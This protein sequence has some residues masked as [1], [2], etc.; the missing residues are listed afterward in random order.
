LTY[1]ETDFTDSDC[2][3]AEAQ[4]QNRID[5]ILFSFESKI[6]EV[7]REEAEIAKFQLLESQA[8]AYANRDYEASQAAEEI[9]SFEANIKSN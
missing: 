5:F 4:L 9:L 3:F 8:E 1:I 6:K 2:E 7:I